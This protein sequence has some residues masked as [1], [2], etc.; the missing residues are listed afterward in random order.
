MNLLRAG[1]IAALLAVTLAAGCASAPPQPQSMRDPDANFA[2]FATFGWEPDRAADGTRRPLSLLD[3][4][5]RTAIAAEMQ[6]RGYAY[7]D[8]NPDL[9]IAFQ[10]ASAQKIESSPVR[11]G[12]GMGS[13][14]GNVGSSV[15]VS[16]SGVR[17]YREGTL[18][19]RAIDA[20]RN[21]E[22][23]QGSIA[24]RLGKESVGQAAV[25]AAVQSVMRDFP[26]R[27]SSD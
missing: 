13:W 26:A 22:V 21:A 23:W 11:V 8:E 5:I 6:R 17:N 3:Q 2:G 20:G 7:A 19:V 10:A 18:V 14:G 12:V 25:T 1:P 16:S 4:N 24:A 9:R 27:Q 15:G